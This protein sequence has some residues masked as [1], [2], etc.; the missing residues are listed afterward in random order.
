MIHQTQKNTETMNEMRN[1]II[2]KLNESINVR[3]AYLQSNFSNEEKYKALKEVELIQA[4]IY[5]IN[6]IK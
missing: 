6:N 3:T 1:K 4:I 5:D 2:A